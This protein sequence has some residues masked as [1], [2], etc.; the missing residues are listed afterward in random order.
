MI[1]IVHRIIEK[2]IIMNN[3][4][5]KSDCEN[6]ITGNIRCRP[7]Q[8]SMLIFLNDKMFWLETI[9][10]FHKDPY[11]WYLEISVLSCSIKSISLIVLCSQNV[12]FILILHY[13]QNRS[14]DIFISRTAVVCSE[15]I[16]FLA[17]LIILFVQV[18]VFSLLLL[19]MLI[20]ILSY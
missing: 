2:K 4:E 14:G 9:Y 5:G 3:K 7:S 6:N 12:L 10:T 18:N 1:F 13:A 20:Y 15:L 8:F 17:C 16:K 19:F 11:I